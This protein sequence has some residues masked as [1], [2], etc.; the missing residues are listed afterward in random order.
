M[1][2]AVSKSGTNDDNVIFGAGQSEVE[3]LD[4]QHKVIADHMTQLILAPIDLSK[5]GL[6][7]LDQATGGGG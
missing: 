5:P 7:I 2:T 4:M 3:R 6:R 1:A